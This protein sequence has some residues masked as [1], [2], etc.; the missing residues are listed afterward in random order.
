[1]HHNAVQCTYLF[2]VIARIS[3][4]HL[5]IISHTKA[6]HALRAALNKLD[7]NNSPGTRLQNLLHLHTLGKE[8]RH[9][10]LD[11]HARPEPLPENFQDTS[12]PSHAAVRVVPCTQLSKEPTTT[13]LNYRSIVFHIP[14]HLFQCRWRHLVP[15][16]YTRPL[17]S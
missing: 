4:R 13:C 5:P 6:M 2:C 9:A 12:T 8:R 14:V 11:A 15:S 16:P 10:R 17:T 3:S 7:L 1:M